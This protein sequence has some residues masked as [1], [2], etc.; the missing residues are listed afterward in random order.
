MRDVKLS[1][2]KTSE[3]LDKFHQMKVDSDKD[4]EGKFNW[5]KSG[6]MQRELDKRLG[7]IPWTTDQDTEDLSDGFMAID[8][9]FEEM[10]KKMDKLKDD[11]KRHRH[12]ATR[13]FTGRAEW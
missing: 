7:R 8:K 12:D 13:K 9:R 10:I 3:L 5:D 4:P 2:M 1:E 11:L 6:E